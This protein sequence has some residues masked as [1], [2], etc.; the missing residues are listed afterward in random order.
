MVKL[1]SS[2]TFHQPIVTKLNQLVRF[3]QQKINNVQFYKKQT[4][5]L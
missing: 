1:V 2:G 5:M 3:K 4:K